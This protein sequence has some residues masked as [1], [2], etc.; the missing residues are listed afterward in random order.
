MM[1]L[2]SIGVQIGEGYKEGK[3]PHYTISPA[4]IW[5]ILKPILQICLSIGELKIITDKEALNSILLLVF[6][7]S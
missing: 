7:I 6:C 1:G 2:R 5:V 3:L 4:Q